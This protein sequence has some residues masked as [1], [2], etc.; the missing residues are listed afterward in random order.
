MRHRVAGRKLSRHTQHRNLMFRNMLVSLL[1]HQRIKTTLAKAKELRRWVDRMV[2]LGKK[3]S[4]HARRQAFALL[5]NEGM[6]KKL[7]NEIAPQLKDREGG[8]TRI[9]KIGWRHGDA[10][11]LSLIELVTFSPAKSEKKSTVTKAKEAIGKVAPRRKGKE[12]KKEKEEQPKE[13]KPKAGAKEKKEKKPKEKQEK[14][15]KEKKKK[16]EDSQ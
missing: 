10:A 3:G 11:P 5:R 1:E 13:R 2:T 14:A 16:K 12:G 7:F 4:L 8:Y 6:V 15:T 9:Y